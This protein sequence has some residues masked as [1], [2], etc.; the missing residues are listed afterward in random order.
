ME[1]F[2]KICERLGLEVKETDNVIYS[3]FMIMK[4]KFW[5]DYVT[6]YIKPAIKLMEGEFLELAVRDAKY[7]GGLSPDKLREVTGIDKYSFETFIC[8]RLINLYISQK[9]LK[10][11][12]II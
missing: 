7:Q 3:N 10:F 2:T 12:Q 1:L 8:E 11:K 5:V 6:N 4:K 9:G